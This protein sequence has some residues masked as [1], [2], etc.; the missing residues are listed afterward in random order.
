[1]RHVPMFAAALGLLFAASAT[2]QTQRQ[3]Q[4]EQRLQNQIR[5]QTAQPVARELRAGV[6]PTTVA[7][8]PNPAP[9]A[10]TRH[11]VND[12][13]FA[14]A[15]ADSGLAEL[16]LSQLGKERA[17]DP[18]LKQFSEEM[19]QE[20]TRM[21]NE[22]FS[23][24][25][26]KQIALP[27]APGYCAQFSAQA[28]AGLSGKEFDHCY[29]QAQLLAH[30]EAVALFEAEAEHGTDQQVAALARKALPDIKQHLEKIKP[31]AKKYM[32]EHQSDRALKGNVSPTES[33]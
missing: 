25:A 8:T 14:A 5:T 17:T 1:M 28:L 22:L 30:M 20:H 18:E 4:I 16:T 21:N 10:T 6:A 23:L 26:Q 19:T 15:A 31:I 29:A 7:P 3:T 32:T 33:R 27:R 12:R 13:L 11:A 24:A 2:A 9:A